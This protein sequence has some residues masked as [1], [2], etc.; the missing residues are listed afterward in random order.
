M[1]NSNIHGEMMEDM[2]R[3]L[4]QLGLT[5]YESK[6]YVSLVSLV[7]AKA[8]ELSKHSNVPRS[9]I[10]SVLENLHE[11]GMINV[12]IGRPI[13]YVM[14]PP[15]ETLYK[16][17]EQ[18]NKDID[19]LE[20]NITKLYESKLPSVKTPIESI[21]D[22]DE[23]IQQFYSIMKKSRD[24][25]CLR[26]GFLI[27]SEIQTFKKQIIYLL[28]K[29]I[30]VEILAVEQ[31]NYNNKNINLKEELSE[32]PAQIKYMNLPAAQLIIRDEKEMML[33]FAQ[34]KDKKVTNRNM[35]GLYNTY[36]TIISNYTSAFYKHYN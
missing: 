8:D 12:K 17:K 4:K 6:V 3:I 25:L 14:I 13:E 36:P 15:Q 7:S 1:S 11:K 16:Y 33:V 27:P 29:G 5:E 22:K 20:E 9:K 28:K 24:K 31:F 35:I 34:S 18:I 10:Y 19:E 30:N 21:E 23:I 32:I 2:V 26:I